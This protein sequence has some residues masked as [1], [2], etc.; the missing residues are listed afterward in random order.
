MT[1]DIYLI[2]DSI[3]KMLAGIGVTLQ[4]L[5]LSS[6]LGLVLGIITLLMRIS[7]RW[8]LSFP[9]YVYIYFFRGC[10]QNK[11]HLSW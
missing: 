2:F 11:G 3:P 6:F 1:F 10:Q 7:G 9:T 5:F 8:Y 4:L